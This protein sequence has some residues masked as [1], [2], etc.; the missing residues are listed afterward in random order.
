MNES[1][2][3]VKSLGAVLE[4]P[5]SDH[6][7]LRVQSAEKFIKVIAADKTMKVNKDT[8]EVDEDVSANTKAV[9]V[10]DAFL[11]WPGRSVF[12]HIDYEPNQGV[13]TSNNGYNAWT[14]PGIEPLKGNTKPFDE[15]M[16]HLVQDETERRHLWRWFA[17]P[18][19]NRGERLNHAVLLWSLN[20]GVGKTALGEVIASLHGES[21]WS[22]VR[23]EQLESSFTEWQLYKT[24]VVVDEV[25]AGSV[26]DSKAFAN[27]MKNLITQK[28]ISINQKFVREF[29][30]RN[31]VNYYLTSNE[32]VAMLTDD[33]ER[34]YFIVH[35]NEIAPNATFFQEFWRWAKSEKGKSAL[36]Y[37]LLHEIDL[38]EFNAMAPPPKTDSFHSMVRLGRS[39]LQNFCHELRDS[40]E[41]V[42]DDVKWAKS[43][44]ATADE[45]LK[46]YARL[47]SDSKV[48]SQQLANEL[49]RAGFRQANGGRQIRVP[50]TNLKLRLWII[51][52]LFAAN[53]TPREIGEEFLKYRSSLKPKHSERG[54]QRK[55]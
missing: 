32:P 39:P 11:K 25:H 26:K 47:N 16:A 54:G 3:V 19:Q 45:L 31:T 55:R 37:K 15:L 10:A 49:A 29:T 23:Q 42:L 7:A 38:T 18:L 9:S 51:N 53:I 50:T 43:P 6:E 22:Q 30:I 44:Y 36:L 34:R 20:R 28:N 52:E 41:T 24:L 4:Y 13:R 35:A 40:R 8:G 1:F 48:N 27:K 12:D 33:K 5:T 14:N 17:H 2:A 21:N 46:V